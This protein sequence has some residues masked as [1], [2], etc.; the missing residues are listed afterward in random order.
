M[1]VSA[2][3]CGITDMAALDAALAGGARRIGLVFYPP[4]PRHMAPAVAAALARRVP[5]GVDRVGV[6]VEPTDEDLAAVLAEVPLDMIQLHGGETPR[7]L[8]ALRERTGLPV[9]KAVPVAG[10]ADLAAA[11]AYE[12][13]A[14]WLLFDAKAAIAAADSLPGG[15][16]VAFDW[17]LLRR[18]HFR[19]PWLLSGGLDAGNVA[20]AVRITGAAHVDVSSGVEARPGVKDPARIGAFLAAV[21]ALAETGEPA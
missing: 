14:D 19:C 18:R 13:V 20:E 5:A 10:E 7:R 9:I 8:A 17:R 16:G 12:D 2:K 4:S 15:R 3:I 6:L 11:G 1:T 21:A